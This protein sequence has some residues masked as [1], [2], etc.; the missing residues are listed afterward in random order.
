M[1]WT[2]DEARQ[3]MAALLPKPVNWREPSIEERPY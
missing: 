2:E 1:D 3:F